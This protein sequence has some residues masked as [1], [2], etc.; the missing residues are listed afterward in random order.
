M[1][2]GKICFFKWFFFTI[3]AIW[4]NYLEWFPNKTLLNPIPYQIFIEIYFKI[5]YIKNSDILFYIIRTKST[6]PLASCFGTKDSLIGV[7]AIY[8]SL[9]W[10]CFNFSINPVFEVAEYIDR[11]TWSLSFH[12]DL[13]QNAT[14][15]YLQP[16]HLIS[17]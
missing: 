5:K 12:W 8:S 14:Q 10:S 16:S 4:V 6:L 3:F 7:M 9:D 11:I 13:W 15:N 17:S 2:E 1:E